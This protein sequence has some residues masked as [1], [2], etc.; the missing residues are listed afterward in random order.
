[1]KTPCNP[2]G[3][4]WG[5]RLVREAWNCDSATARLYLMVIRAWPRM[6]ART[7]RFP[8]RSASANHE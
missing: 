2:L 3:L 4:G 5:L 6:R 8:G 7:P 1:M